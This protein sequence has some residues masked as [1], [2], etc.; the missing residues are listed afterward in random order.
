MGELIHELVEDWHQKLGFS[1]QCVEVSE[2][3][4]EMEGAVL[5]FDQQHRGSKSTR[6]WLNDPL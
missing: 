5:L 4:V 3:Y 1:S 2:V 6:A